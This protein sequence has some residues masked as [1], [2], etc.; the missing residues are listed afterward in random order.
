MINNQTQPHNTNKKPYTLPIKIILFITIICVFVPFSPIIPGQNP[1][2]LDA[3][4]EFGLNQ[5]VAQNLSFGKQLIFTFGPYASIYTQLYHPS[6]DNLMMI[7]SI[8]L[9]I[10]YWIS[11]AFLAKNS[12]QRWLWA[13]FAIFAGIGI[14]RDTLLFAYPLLAGLSV[15]KITKENS[16]SSI[17]RILLTAILFLPFGLLPL[18]KGTAIVFCGA[19]LIFSVFLFLTINNKALGIF[20]ALTCLSA[21][22]I[23]MVIFWMLS[24]QKISALPWYFINMIPIVSGYTEAMAI[25]GSNVEIPIYLIPSTIFVLSILLQNDI[26]KQQKVFL[27]LTCFSFLFIS[28]KEGFVRHDGHAMV[29]ADSIMIASFLLPMV[30]E[31]KLFPALILTT[32]LAWSALDMHYIETSTSTFWHNFRL[33]YSS[34]WNGLRHRI[35]GTNWPKSD[36][37]TSILAL[38]KTAAF[39]KLVGTTDIYSWNQSYLFGSG[40][41]WNPRPVFQSYSVYTPSLAKLNQSHLL[42]KRSPDNIIFKVEPID[43]RLPSLEDGASWEVLLTHY[44]PTAVKNDFL[45]LVKKGS[46]FKNPTTSPITQGD[47]VFGSIVPVPNVLAPI[48][49][50]ITINMNTIGKITN[51]LYKPEHLNIT[52]NL[53][54]GTTESYRIISGMTESGVLIS[55]LV[56][57]T[58][59][60]ASLYNE[61]NIKYTEKVK[62]FSI[63][64]AGYKWEWKNTFHVAFYQVTD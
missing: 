28:F 41:T 43:G 31:S 9:G 23:S 50:K 46:Q 63:S 44:Q 32:I 47:Y 18:I 8:Y 4:W 52:L 33:T 16:T 49:A 19:V 35:N 40:N 62:S 38:N 53:E 17:N 58:R 36:F 11:I 60:F 20:L 45:Y 42:E 24:G 61:K 12:R 1:D 48:F 10:S 39:P 6:T 15:F 30:I 34:A 51:F 14:S 37:E 3:S 25:D 56:R 7:G 2:I 13:I 22:A 59:D 55:P 5:A 29:A 54:N 64:P 21:P 57:N 26:S 27:F